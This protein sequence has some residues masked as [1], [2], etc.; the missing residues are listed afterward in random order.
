MS[1]AISMKLVF[2]V[3]LL[4]GLFWPA[5]AASLRSGTH[6][7]QRAVNHAAKDV[8]DTGKDHAGAK[9]GEEEEDDDDDDDEDD[10]D[11]PMNS[12]VKMRQ[13]ELAK[14][15][16]QLEKE[17]NPHA[18]EEA[19][20]KKDLKVAE[21]ELAT[22]LAEQASMKHKIEHLT[23][24]S[25]STMEINAQTKLVANQTE[26]VALADMLGKMWKEM[27]MFEV[28]FY[29]QHIEEEIHHLKREEKSLEDK[30][31]SAQ[32]ALTK[33]QAKWAK[34]EK[35]K[36]EAAKKKAEKKAEQ[37]EE[38][39][40]AE[41]PAKKKA[42]EAAPAAASE[43]DMGDGE[44]ALPHKQLEKGVHDAEANI[45]QHQKPGE[46]SIWHM[47]Y[48]MRW[49]VLGYTLVY[50]LFGV[51]M[52]F[53]YNKARNNS[54]YDH[55]F[56]PKRV[57]GTTASGKDFTFSL[58]GCFGDIPMCVL[59]CCCPVLRWADTVS[60][61]KLLSFWKAFFIFFILILLH[62]YTFG[63]STLLAMAVGVYYRQRL[64]S[65]YGMSDSRTLAT[66]CIDLLA[67]TFCQPC[68]IIQEAR[69]EA[70]ERF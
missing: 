49:V 22:N 37:D 42:E 3:C 62:V 15:E 56:K 64:R 27:R 53:L 68:A 40:D 20:L 1:T 47:S 26:S 69:E 57:P 65:H 9:G 63:I 46:W 67:W 43:E 38:A 11:S 34:E 24:E 70:V 45:E 2:F 10:E 8:D 59:G 41:A 50:F 6:R 55:L 23:D 66:I 21:Q 58:F 19:R 29:A 16:D 35:A 30:V 12:T 52:A 60:Q 17:I 44:A 31:T 25:A 32:A 7:K 51:L 14:K 54:K 36:K 5:D 33:A 28:P 48:R 39:E 18:A 4:L 61:P 13:T